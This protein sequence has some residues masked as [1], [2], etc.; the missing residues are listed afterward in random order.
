M[1]KVI[2]K[3][4]KIYDEEPVS[5]CTACL[6]L[7]IKRLEKTNTYYCGNCG[8]TNLDTTSI[9]NWQNKYKKRYGEIYIKKNMKKTTLNEIS[10]WIKTEKEIFHNFIWST[11][12]E[13]DTILKI[14]KTFII[15]HPEYKIKES[16]LNIKIWK[17]V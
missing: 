9:N 7:K 12:F 4:I 6:S 13:K 8:N 5:Y 14:L 2:N 17:K 11:E 16:K 10:N 15:L 3:N 1:N